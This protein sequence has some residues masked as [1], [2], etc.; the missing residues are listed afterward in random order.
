MDRNLWNEY[1]S[2]PLLTLFFFFFHLQEWNLPNKVG[3]SP[4]LKR[5]LLV[6]ICKTSNILAAHS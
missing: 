2:I 4:K 5:V 6:L 1:V 3:A